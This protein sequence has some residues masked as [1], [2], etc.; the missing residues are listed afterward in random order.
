MDTPIPVEPPEGHR[1]RC[2]WWAKIFALPRWEIRQGFDGK[3]RKQKVPA[4]EASQL[5]A[6]ALTH[7]A[8]FTNANL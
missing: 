2:L 6:E 4:S 7:Y 1:E 3:W 8:E 5:A